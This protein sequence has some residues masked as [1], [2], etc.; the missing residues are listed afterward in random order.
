MK[1]IKQ[2]P[3][4]LFSVVLFVINWM[5]IWKLQNPPAPKDC[6]DIREGLNQCVGALEQC[7]DLN[8]LMQKTMN[9]HVQNMDKI[10]NHE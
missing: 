5:L 8:N 9:E 10:L 7:R 1:T 3:F 6:L 2:N 4:I